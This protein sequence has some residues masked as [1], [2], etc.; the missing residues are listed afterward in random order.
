M[1]GR[2]AQRVQHARMRCDPAPLM[3]SR[4]EDRA[5]RE[6]DQ[7]AEAVTAEAGPAPRPA[8]AAM[9]LAR[10]PSAP[11]P[12]ERAADPGFARAL[13]AAAPGRPLPA[14][15]R[16]YFEPRFGRDLSA[17]RVHDDAHAAALGR[18]IDARA[19]A[20]GSDIYFGRAEY[21]PG[22]AAGRRL[23]AHE[24]THALQPQPAGRIARKTLTDLPEA[25]RK[26]LKI[27][28]VA[29]EKS[30]V[31][32]WIKDY[33]D[34]KSGTSASPS[35]KPE[36][37][38][39]ITDKNIKNG[40]S[41]VAAELLSL[42]RVVVIPKTE[43]KP[44]ERTQTD[45]E[46]WPL[47]PNAIL[48]LALDLRPQGGEHAIFRFVR[49]SE[50][51]T[52]KLLIERTHV[53]APAPAAGTAP[54]TPKAPATGGGATA[55]SFTGDVKVGGVTVKID[56][57]VGDDRGRAIAQA[58]GLLPAPIQ[59]KADG[60]GFDY[61]GKGKGPGG[62]NGHY[63]SV[64][65]VVTVWGDM[66]A[67]SARRTGSASNTSYQIVHEL[68]HVIDLRPLFA[69]QIA[70]G[71][72]KERKAE[73]EKEMRT[74]ETKFIDPNDPLG[75]LSSSGGTDPR[76]E[77][78]KKRIQG[79]IDKANADIKRHNT[80]I[81]TAKSV[82]GSEIG[83]DTESMLTDFAKAIAA[84][85][86]KV[87]TDAK[88]RNR[89]VEAANAAA[90]EANAKNPSGAQIPM[91]DTEKTLAGGIS[92]Y[93]ATDLMEA[94]AENFSYYVLDEALLKAI[95]PKTHAYFAKAYPKTQATTP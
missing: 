32:A 4:P 85:G 53:L 9:P 65:D 58:V 92:D 56:V 7:I 50:G 8:V 51:T 36:Y 22:T 29:P 47:A 54:V 2:S 72:A 76:V 91:K 24:I 75:G 94:F 66:F 89:A 78:E 18:A 57:G 88:K 19:F 44:E 11:P 60:V 62:Q 55:P 13:D 39:E 6:A 35:L 30:V 81:G 67:A 93:A 31:D 52:E 38:T 82:A 42:S 90:E 63:D 17:V 87:K 37:G 23:I 79:E 74:A 80:A 64:K 71:K 43:D 1:S 34:P 16:T 14:S 48:D 59:A 5:E 70:E 46:T 68:A 77:A 27:S 61:G 25:T 49:Y 84:D 10:A 40:L 26:G 41:S 15:E 86:V 12:P 20:R 28:R 69:A 95:R 83:K 3:L 33:F 73:L 21:R 45:P